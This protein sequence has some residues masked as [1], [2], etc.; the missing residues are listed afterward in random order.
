MPGA[1]RRRG[2]CGFAIAIER[3]R[4]G[5]HAYKKL[6]LNSRFFAGGAGLG[7]L[8]GSFADSTGKI[9]GRAGDIGAEIR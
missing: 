4:F 1:N 7:R 2:G 3:Q 5:K 6:T 8:S 9:E